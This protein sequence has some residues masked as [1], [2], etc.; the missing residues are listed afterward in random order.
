MNITINELD[1]LLESFVKVVCNGRDESHGYAHMKK[2]KI[3]SLKIFKEL[4]GYVN[5]EYKL[6]MGVYEMDI[7]LQTYYYLEKL[8]MT[9]AWLHDVA[10]KLKKIVYY[11]LNGL[12]PDNRCAIAIL[13]QNIIDRISYSKE[14][15]VRM[16]DKVLDWKIILGFEG[17]LV[18]D[19]VSD[20]DKLEALGKIGLCRCIEFASHKYKEKNGVDIQLDILKQN[21][22]EHATE[23]LLRL[24][25]EFIRTPTGYDMATV[26]HD[27]FVEEFEK[28]LK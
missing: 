9:V 8:T 7:D 19:V 3:N 12:Y 21:V 28:F 18:R 14:N 25:D 17:C 23:K 5:S 10:D 20:A 24:K 4:F 22:K 27:E 15:K 2:V 26:L 13:I 16:S 6:C 1:E 11:F